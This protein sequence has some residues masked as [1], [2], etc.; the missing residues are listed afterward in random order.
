MIGIDQNSNLIYEGLSFHGHGLWPAPLL[1]RA[2][3]VLDASGWDRVPSTGELRGASCVFREDHFD[4]VTRIRRGRFYD[5][6]GIRSQPDSWWVHRH[7]VIHDEVGQVNH[8]GL[9]AKTLVTF[10][11]MRRV[12]EQLQ[13]ARDPIVV[14]GAQPAVSAW[15][16]VSVERA[17]GEHD[18]VTLKARLNFGFLPELISEAIPQAGRE[19]VTREIAKVVDA[20]HRQS[21]IAL[22]DLCR[23]AAT[24]VLAEW[25]V[26][27]GA[28]DLIRLQDLGQVIAKMPPES[29]LRRS[30][31]DIIRLLHPRGK[32]N[33]QLRLGT[34]Q[35]TE[36]DGGFALDA[37]AFLLRDL[38]WAR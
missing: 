4:P 5:T 33:E 20:A 8:Q 31:A 14:L 10:T 35:V 27:Q 36:A 38:G 23:A 9:F 1:L 3:F 19:R 21:G 32:P 6:L 2:T 15:S 11:P 12:V 28:P 30:A 18:V 13:S 29:T 24:V 37:L 7:P 26:S 34:P 16:V 17:D 25:L 22:V